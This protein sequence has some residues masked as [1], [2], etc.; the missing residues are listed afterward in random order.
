MRVLR[1][2]YLGWVAKQGAFGIASYT[3]RMILLFKSANLNERQ[4]FETEP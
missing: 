3:Y 4:N 1:E 2:L